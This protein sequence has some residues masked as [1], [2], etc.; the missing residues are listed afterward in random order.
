MKT[1]CCSFLGLVLLVGM[2]G[3]S[4]VAYAQRGPGMGQR[5]YDP[6]TVE[7]VTGV[8]TAVDTVTGRRGRQHQGIHVRMTASG[9]PLTVH[10]GPLFHLQQQTVRVQAG[11]T[12]TVRGSRV[13]MR[14]EPSLIAAELTRQDQT[15]RLRDE[16]GF[17]RWRGQ[18]R[19][20]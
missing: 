1:Q 2:L 12:L 10:L 15:W 14:G 9:E 16:Q 11:D 17:P 6:S 18:R 3:C 5:M 4:S 7:T 20:N 8:V 19:Q 13:T